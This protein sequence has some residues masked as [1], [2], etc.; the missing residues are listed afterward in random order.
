MGSE[1]RGGEGCVGGV[2]VGGEG[3]GEREGFLR[4]VMGEEV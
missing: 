3:V 2:E 4:F 1:E